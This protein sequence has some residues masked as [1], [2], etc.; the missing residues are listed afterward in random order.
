L[1]SVKP[2]CR[3]AE[4]CVAVFKAKTCARGGVM[5]AGIAA[6]GFAAALAAAAAVWTPSAPATARDVMLLYVGAD[7]CAPCRTWQRADGPSFRASPEFSRVTYREVKSPSV[8]D[9]LKDEY[10]PEDLRPYRER[11]GRAAAVPLWLVVADEA[12]VEQAFG[13]SQWRDAVLPKLR[14]LLR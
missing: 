10:W 7:D 14:S 8:L 9:I 3:T 6:T 5:R 1:I 11:I 13:V 12:L 2:F 4:Y